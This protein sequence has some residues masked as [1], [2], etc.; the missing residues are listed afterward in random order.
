M[1]KVKTTIHNSYVPI[2][3][4]RICSRSIQ[5][6]ITISR[7]VN[8]FFMPF[9]ASYVIVFIAESLKVNHDQIREFVFF[10]DSDLSF[11]LG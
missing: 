1:I 2:N 11:L 3:A 9:F 6:V 7:A 4:L 10:S 5:S 8:G